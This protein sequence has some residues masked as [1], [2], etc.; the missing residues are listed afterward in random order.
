M[1]ATAPVPA[2]P[3]PSTT[4]DA[5]PARAPEAT[6]DEAADRQQEKVVRAAF[7]RLGLGTIAAPATVDPAAPVTAAPAQACTPIGTVVTT[8]APEDGAALATHTT[9]RTQHAEDELP[10]VRGPP[11]PLESPSSPVATAASGGAAPGGVSGERDCAILAD[12]VVFTLADGGYPAAADC[13]DHVAPAPANAAA[14]A[15]PVV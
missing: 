12:H 7:K 11:T 14:R 1:P 10:L 6:D 8:P 9:V 2:A 5:N 13:C 15:P 3:T 4:A